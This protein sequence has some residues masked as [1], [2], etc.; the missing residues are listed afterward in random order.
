MVTALMVAL[1]GAAPLP[2]ARLVRGAPSAG[3]CEMERLSSTSTAV[4]WAWRS[5]CGLD[6]VQAH[7]A[8][9]G[10]VAVGNYDFAPVLLFDETRAIA[11]APKAK[12]PFA[13][14]LVQAVRERLGRKLP[15]GFFEMLTDSRDGSVL[16]MHDGKLVRIVHAGEPEVPVF[17]GTPEMYAQRDGLAWPLDPAL[18]NPWVVFRSTATRGVFVVR[19]VNPS[20]EVRELVTRPD[21]LREVTRPAATLLRL[22][23]AELPIVS[24]LGADGSHFIFVPDPTKPGA[25][26]SSVF[27]QPP[28]S[29]PASPPPDVSTQ[30]TGLPPRCSETVLEYTGEARTNPALFE[31]TGRAFIAYGVTTTHS[32]FRFTLVARGGPTI[33]DDAFACEWVEDA[34][35]SSPK[36]VIASITPDGALDKRLELQLFDPPAQLT[37]DQSP[38]HLTVLLKGTALVV[39]SLEPG[40]RS[41][42]GLLA[43]RARATSGA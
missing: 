39:L 28:I 41:G 37:V 33:D 17:P 42:G 6:W 34:R 26:R 7:A 32:T 21:T 1:L 11:V 5:S 8:S 30:P 23:E 19:L 16:A 15:P 10:S 4:K 20:G 40:N 31:H 24:A 29:A 14:E 22:P 3:P 27:D 12:A 35:R 18:K 38:A 2:E 25:L 36:L 43:R 9:K 13:G